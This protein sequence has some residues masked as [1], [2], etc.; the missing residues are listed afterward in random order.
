MHFEKIG[1][2]THDESGL[3]SLQD[4]SLRP[5]P[6][7]LPSSAPLP[8]LLNRSGCRATISRIQPHGTP[9]LS[10]SPSMCTRTSYSTTIAPI[11]RQQH[12][13]RRRPTQAAARLPTHAQTRSLGPQAL[14]TTA[15][16]NSSSRNSTA[17]TRH[18]SGV[19]FPPRRLPALRTSPLGPGPFSRNAVSPSSSPRNGP[20]TR[21][22]ASATRARV[23]RSSASP[24]CA[25][26]RWLGRAYGS[27]V[28]HLLSSPTR[29]QCTRRRAKGKL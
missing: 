29:P 19:R 6:G 8:H 16:A 9:P 13:K 18:S 27:P 2:H 22:S 26:E 12:N 5:T 17:S 3:T 7:L 25:H 14:R 20:S 23:L 28:P 1:T 15:T 4:A 24:G 11:S 10:A 21:P